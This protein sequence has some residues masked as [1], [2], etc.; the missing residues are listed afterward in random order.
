[1]RAL[2]DPPCPTCHRAGALGRYP[3]N[4]INILACGP[5]IPEDSGIPESNAAA[6]KSGIARGYRTIWRSLLPSLAA[7]IDKIGARSNLKKE[8][9]RAL[10]A[11]RRRSELHIAG[12]KSAAHHA[13]RPVVEISERHADRKKPDIVTRVWASWLLRL[14]HANATQYLIGEKLSGDHNLGAVD[15]SGAVPESAICTLA[16]CMPELSWKAQLNS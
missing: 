4:R 3:G 6:E 13:S 2:C 11:G 15:L 16:V 1:M 5:V 7:L 8:R 10:D 14:Y 12:S 9:W